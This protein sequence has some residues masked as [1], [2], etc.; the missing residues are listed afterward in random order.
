[1]RAIKFRMWSTTAAKF[2]YEP[3]TVYDCLRFSQREDTKHLYTDMVWQQFTGLK[4]ANGIDIYEGDVVELYFKNIDLVKDYYKKSKDTLLPIILDKI[5]DN[6]YREVVTFDN[7][8]SILGQFTYYIGVIPFAALKC[9]V[10][11]KDIN[12]VGDIFKNEN[13]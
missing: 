11:E 4:D 12:V 6:V 7:E 13:N 9:L 10:G 8:Q 5:K 3:C 2:F 1:M